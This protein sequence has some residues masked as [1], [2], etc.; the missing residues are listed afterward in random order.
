MC[1][2]IARSRWVATTLLTLSLPACGGNA[3]LASVQ[4][5]VTLDGQPLANAF[6]IFSPT[7]NGT[8]AYG[9]TDADG[10]FKMMFTDRE[11]G[12]WI[13]ENLV[14]IN[15][16]DLRRTGGVIR[17]QVPLVYNAKTK[18]KTDVKPGKNTCNFD[19]KSDAG[20]IVQPLD[21]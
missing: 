9:K 21:R 19:L 8:T 3:N 6:V 7:A 11:A 5:R 20:K 13:G 17:E 2:L 16:G 12:A 10:Y 15:T 14:R 18:L 1:R 4:G